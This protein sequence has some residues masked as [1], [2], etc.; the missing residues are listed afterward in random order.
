MSSS[1]ELDL[2]LASHRSR[3]AEEARLELSNAAHDI[4]RFTAYAASRGVTL[5]ADSF[6]YLPT[7]G[8]VAT[9][10]GLSR[11]LLG[12]MRTERDGLLAFGDIA[13]RLPPS[14][15]QAGYFLGP[16]YMLMADSCFR[17]GMYP[18][19]NWAPR[20]IEIFWESN[21]SGAE[22][23]IG[24]DEDR[25]RV[26]VDG[27]AYFERDTWYGAPF[28]EDIRL[29]TP[30]TVKLRP[31]IGVGPRFV[32]FFFAQAYC[33][34]IKWTEAN[35]I[36][37][38]QALELKTESVQLDLEGIVHF[39]AR[40]MHAEFDVSANSFRHFDGAI[41][42]FRETEYFQRRDSDF[43]V[44]KKTLDHVKARS[45]KV[46]KLNG[47]I[48][49]E[50]WVELCCHFLPANPLTFEYFTGA[51]PSHV[52]DAVA[53]ARSGALRLDDASTI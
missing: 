25:V 24:I 10:P 11:R 42:L 4:K 43:N 44:I 28:K 30:G 16:E 49:T 40:Y 38:F 37:T 7:I 6:E 9:A 51:Y 1:A 22:K 35:G 21:F 27:P 29:I 8:I 41:Q 34:D 26:D 46:F 19:D 50:D 2:M 32:D 13:A 12:P 17:R 52:S 23:Y 33:W 20:F 14:K 45:R 36:K 18:A 47:Q 3:L 31:P 48:K 5:G 53:R 39:P 15:L